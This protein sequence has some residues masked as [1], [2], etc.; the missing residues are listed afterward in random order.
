[1]IKLFNH[2]NHTINIYQQ[3]IC[4]VPNFDLAP[5]PCGGHRA[6]RNAMT[7]VF[8][9]DDAD[10]FGFLP[11]VGEDIDSDVGGSGGKGRRLTDVGPL[12]WRK[13]QQLNRGLLWSMMVYDG[14]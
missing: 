6:A 13:I 12:G 14:L 9:F 7:S 11:G 1:M 10:G 8:S 5:G 3:H 2:T 4:H